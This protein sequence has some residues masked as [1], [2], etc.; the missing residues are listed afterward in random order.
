VVFLIRVVSRIRARLG[1]GA[2]P[3]LTLSCRAIC[4]LG[5]D[6]RLCAC[7]AFQRA[8]QALVYEPTTLQCLCCPLTGKGFGPSRPRFS[9][10]TF[11]QILAADYERSSAVYEYSYY[12]S[13]TEL[14]ALK[15]AQA[16]S[17]QTIIISDQ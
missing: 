15:L 7:A 17:N 3:A 9:K 1:V 2:L 14:E 16:H 5:N 13:R 4:S 12:R 8:L 6:C 10:A 11:A